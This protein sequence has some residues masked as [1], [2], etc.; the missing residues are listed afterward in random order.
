M[1]FSKKSTLYSTGHCRSSHYFVENLFQTSY[2]ALVTSLPPYNAHAYVCLA[3]FS[4][5]SSLLITK[6]MP[7]SKELSL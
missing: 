3:S 4:T 7:T 5:F 2:H 1:L 6:P